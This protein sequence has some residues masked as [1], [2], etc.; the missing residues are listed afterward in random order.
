MIVRP[1][2]A[3]GPAAHFEGEDLITPG[4]L[5]VS[6]GVACFP[7][8]ANDAQELILHAD[9]ALYKAKTQGKM[10]LGILAAVAG[11]G[12]AV[13]LFLFKVLFLFTWL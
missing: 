10:V 5:T 9:E 4:G 11:A 6:V 13:L 7:E 3:F 12:A 8:H 1:F 2:N